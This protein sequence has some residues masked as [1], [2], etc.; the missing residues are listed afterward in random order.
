MSLI[1]F[2]P[3]SFLKQLIRS[4]KQIDWSIKNNLFQKKNFN[5]AFFPKRIRQ[6]SDQFSRN[7]EHR[8][9]GESIKIDQNVKG[10]ISST[11]SKL[12]ELDIIAKYLQPKK[13]SLENIEVDK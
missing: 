13:K 2:Y 4:L 6:V 1:F 9:R 8:E 10:R 3:N 5:Y 7:I 11:G 12:K